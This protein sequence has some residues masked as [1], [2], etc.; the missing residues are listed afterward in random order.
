MIEGNS[1]TG[2]TQ[3]I[4]IAAGARNTTIRDNTVIGNPS[5]QVGATNASVRTADIV[6]MAPEGQTRFERN[7]CVTGVNAPCPIVSKPPQN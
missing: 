3:G 6:N 2:N 4:F 7:V 5:I 1:V